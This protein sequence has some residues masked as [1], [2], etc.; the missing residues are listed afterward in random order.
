MW[1]V[2]EIYLWAT[3]LKGK[4]IVKRSFASVAAFSSSIKEKADIEGQTLAKSKV[5]RQQLR[6]KGKVLI[7]QQNLTSKPYRFTL[8][9]HYDINPNT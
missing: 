4:T 1:A 5:K 7:P 8:N 9:G 6:G 3:S 2:V